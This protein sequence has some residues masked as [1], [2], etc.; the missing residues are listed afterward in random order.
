MSSEAFTAF[1][2]TT[3]GHSAGSCRDGVIAFVCANFLLPDG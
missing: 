3:L 1:L 2:Q